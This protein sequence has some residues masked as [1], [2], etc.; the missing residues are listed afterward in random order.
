MKST[1][2][3]LWV[4]GAGL[5]VSAHAGDEAAGKPPT[6]AT[7]AAEPPWAFAVCAYPT[8]V[9]GGPRFTTGV[10]TADRGPLHLEA[11]INY[12]SGGARSLFAGWNV[13]GGDAVK[14]E[15]TPLLGSAWGSTQAWIP[16]LE[17]S[18]SWQ[19]WDV[20]VESEY[21]RTRSGLADSYLYAWTELGFRPLPWLR[22]GLA[23][24][25]TRLYGG[26]R[27]YQRGPLLQASW[28]PLTLGAYWFNP[29]SADQIVMGMVSAAF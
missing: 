7:A 18:V 11:R 29:G 12:E 15:L 3:L 22:V 19:R 14:W 2:H 21:V 17:A 4:F 1:R 27:Q 10:A 25:R 8:A 9:R 28:G 26:P 13:S 24:Q 6:Q 5:A 16:G 20:Y 23:G